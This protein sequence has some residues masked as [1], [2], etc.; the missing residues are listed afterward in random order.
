MDGD[1]VNVLE[2]M[3]GWGR[4]QCEAALALGNRCRRQL[5]PPGEVAVGRVPCSP[6]HRAAPALAF[7]HM[8]AFEGDTTARQGVSVMQP[9]RSLTRSRRPSA[10]GTVKPIVPP[11]WAI[12]ARYRIQPA[13]TD[14]CGACGCPVAPVRHSH[15]RR[16]QFTIWRRPTSAQ[17][18][19]RGKLQVAV[20]RL[21]IGHISMHIASLAV[22]IIRLE[23][24]RCFVLC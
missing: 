14:A 13:G 3:G 4:E 20:S 23:V 1:A 17:A 5:G 24:W 6:P 7:P 9:R 10:R 16:A 18:R 8:C 12:A 11:A 21:S 19:I 2:E 22:A 15:P